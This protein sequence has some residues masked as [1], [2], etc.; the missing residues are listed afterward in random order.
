MKLKRDYCLSLIRDL[1]E[2]VVKGVQKFYY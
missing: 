1:N 2:K